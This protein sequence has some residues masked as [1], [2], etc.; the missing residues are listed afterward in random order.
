MFDIKEVLNA[1]EQIK[2]AKAHF[3]GDIGE[4]AF[5]QFAAEYL[6]S[7]YNILGNIV[8]K[9]HNG[10]TQ[11][12]QIIISKFGIFV[13]EIKNYKGW[14]F[15]NENSSQWTQALISG[16]YRFQNP[17]RQNYKHIKTLQNLLQYPDNFFKSLIVFSAE[18]EFKTPLPINVVNCGEDFIYL[19]E[20][21]Q[22][23]LLS[24]DE[25]KS[26]IQIIEKHCLTPEE[27]QQHIQ[28]IKNQYNSA[29]ENNPPDCPNC[30]NKMILRMAKSGTNT[31]NK[32]W[33][34]S[35]YPYCKRIVNIDNQKEK[36]MQTINQVESFLNM[37]GF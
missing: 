23:I 4:I 13:I 36:M 22:T 17:L 5:F 35:K 10:T 18:S 15:G 26:I 3:I 12:D 31:G 29:D 8:L 37:M 7:N 34:C 24:D 25:V 1:V 19:I 9:T 16:K 33:G 21:H 6:D 32:F 30:G 2:E 14:I 28:K 11:I 20:S 27:H